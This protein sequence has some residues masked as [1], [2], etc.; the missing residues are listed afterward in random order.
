MSI[1]ETRAELL[2]LDDK[3][4]AVGGRRPF[5]RFHAPLASCLGVLS[6]NLG[7]IEGAEW[8]KL[9]RGGYLPGLINRA[10]PVKYVSV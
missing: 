10:S 3:V 8:M 7:T 9:K 4:Y 6:V 5:H 1:S 2:G